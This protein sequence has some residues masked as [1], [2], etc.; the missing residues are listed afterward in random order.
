MIEFSILGRSF[1]ATGTD[2]ALAAMLRLRYDFPEYVLPEHPFQIKLE[3]LSQ[4]PTDFPETTASDQLQMLSGPMAIW[5][6]D[7]IFWLGSLSTGGRIEVLEAGVKLALWGSSDSRFE[8]AMIGLAEGLRASG[9]ISLHT[10]MPARD[11]RAL[12]LLGP[13]GRGKTTSLIRALHSGL[14]PVCEDFAWCEPS[15][16]RVYGFDR[17]LRLLPD[18]AELFKQLF[19]MQASQIQSNQVQAGEWQGDKWFV[20]YSSFTQRQNATLVALVLLERQPE[21]PTAWLEVA[22]RAAAL[23]LWEASGM[24]LSGVVQQRTSQEIGRLARMPA[25]TLRLGQGE[26]DWASGP[27][28]IA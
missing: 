24:P 9:L 2:A 18:T 10:S 13:S 7:P 14:Q 6:G 19:Q 20:P 15:T 25:Y 17:G 4:S 16:A 21:L 8:I 12:A 3:V 1:R 27:L 22:P 11:G 26:I 28:R 5:N 23:A